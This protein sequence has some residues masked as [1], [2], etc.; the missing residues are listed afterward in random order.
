MSALDLADSREHEEAKEQ[1]VPSND[2]PTLAGT[3]AAEAEHAEWC[4]P[5]LWGE[6]I[7]EFAKECIDEGENTKD[8]DFRPPEMPTWWSVGDLPSKS[9]EKEDFDK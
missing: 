4:L 9:F 8:P 3:V 6:H 5:A 1:L 7:L 2:V